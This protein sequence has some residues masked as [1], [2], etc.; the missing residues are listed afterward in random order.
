MQADLHYIYVAVFSLLQFLVLLGLSPVTY[1]VQAD[2][3]YLFVAN[4][5]PL[6]IFGASWS[7]LQFHLSNNIWWMCQGEDM[8][9]KC[10]S[11]HHSPPW[12]FPSVEGIYWKRS[13]LFCCRLIWLQLHS[14]L[15]PVTATNKAPFSSFS[16]FLLGCVVSAS[17]ACLK[18]D[19]GFE[20]SPAF[21][22]DSSLSIS[23][24]EIGEIFR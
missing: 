5:S 14:P 2:H 19:P 12:W 23:E 24:E 18:E 11:T 13:M 10:V 17:N 1:L 16:I 6:H 8:M 7:P 22:G 21:F 20:L 4:L 15:P 3:R 9:M